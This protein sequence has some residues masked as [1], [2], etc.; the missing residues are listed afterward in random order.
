MVFV[1]SVKQGIFALKGFRDETYFNISLKK[2][3][4]YRPKRIEKQCES[5]RE[6]NITVDMMFSFDE[7]RFCLGRLERLPSRSIPLDVL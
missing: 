6:Y 7:R 5:S 2:K 3:T 1:R 4:D